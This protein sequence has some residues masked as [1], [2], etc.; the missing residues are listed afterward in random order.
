M[1]PYDDAAISVASAGAS[2]V[3]GLA[4]MAAAADGD[5]LGWLESRK[6]CD[7]SSVAAGRCA[8]SHLRQQLMKSAATSLIALGRGG[9]VGPTLTMWNAGQYT[10][11]SSGQGCFPVSIS[12]TVQPR[13]Q[14]SGEQNQ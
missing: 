13:D 3:P 9:P 10:P 11:A 4:A 12:M 2:A 7:S 8:G 5:S 1:R 14:I 6:G